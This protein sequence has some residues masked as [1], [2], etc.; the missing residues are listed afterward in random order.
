MFFHISHKR[1]IHGILYTR[2]HKPQSYRVCNEFQRLRQCV[3]CG[4]CD[5]GGEVVVAPFCTIPCCSVKVGGGS[6]VSC[7]QVQME[8]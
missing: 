2:Y 1:T 8:S 3:L 7:V 5:G 4:Q 6:E